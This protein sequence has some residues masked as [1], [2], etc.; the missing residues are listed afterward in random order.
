MRSLSAVKALYTLFPL[1]MVQPLNGGDKDL[2]FLY[3]FHSF[4]PLI[5]PAALRAAYFRPNGISLRAAK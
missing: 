5:L 4:F 3:Y 2:F 1:K